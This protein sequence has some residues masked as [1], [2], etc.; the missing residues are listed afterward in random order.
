MTQD[1]QRILFLCTGNSCRSQMAEGF[2][3]SLY[4]D[5]F[6]ACSAGAKP[7]GYVHPMAVAAMA[8]VG[9]DI[10]QQTSK[11]I[12]DFLPPST[13]VPDVIIG[14]CSTADENCPVFPGNVERWQWPFDDPYHAEGDDEHR[15]AEFRR[16]RDEIRS[17]I[18]QQFAN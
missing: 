8:E 7:A 6:E 13:A 3:R 11:S 10:S 17:R 5:R 14:V 12:R 9:I 18:E 15:K 16:V 4:G 1:R 2:L